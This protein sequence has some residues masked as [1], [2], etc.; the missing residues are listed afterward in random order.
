MKRTLCYLRGTLDYGI[1]LRRSAS[2]K[3]M[4]YTNVDWVGCPNTRRSTLGY[5]MFLGA[6]LVSWYS[7]RQNVVSRSSAVAEYRAVPNGVAEACW[8]R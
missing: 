1:L 8:L 4:V 6:N 7:K 5:T 3:L 2:S